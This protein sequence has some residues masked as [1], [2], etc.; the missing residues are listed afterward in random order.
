MSRLVASLQILVVVLIVTLLASDRCFA[1]QRRSPFGT[2]R[3]SLATLP[4][5]QEALNLSDEQKQLADSL[6]DQMTEDRREVF[7]SGGGDFDGMR[8]KM[9]KL[10][11]DATG[12]F[13][14]KLDDTQKVRL[15][16]IYVQANGPNALSDP[17]VIETLKITPE[18]ASKLEE[19]RQTNRDALFGAF[20]DF[21][22]MSDEEGREAFGKL[23]QEG[24]DRLL[25]GLTD[26]QQAAFDK[27][28]GEEVDFDLTEIRGSFGGGGRPAAS[29][30]DRPQRPQ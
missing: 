14:E 26:E 4:T 24:D 2:S 5:V 30:S 3:V 16:E 7:Q 11:A 12:K 20:Q 13:S 22:D 19:L 23:Q 17:M 10:D 18:Q 28:P 6:H 21:Q 1:Q 25:G 15:T 27:L 8:V 9:E 29:S